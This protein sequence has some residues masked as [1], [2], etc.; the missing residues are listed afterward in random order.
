MNILLT[1]ASGFLGSRFYRELS[2]EN[3]VTTLSRTS[4]GDWPG[5]PRHIQCDLARQVPVLP[6]EP[7][8]IVVHSAGKAHS[9]PRTASERNDYEHVNVQGTIRLLTAL[10]QLPTLPKSLVYISSVLVYG[11]LQ[12]YCLAENTPPRA[13]DVYGLSKVKAE[14]AVR[15]WSERTGVRVAILRLPLVV[16]EQP[17]GNLL[18]MLNAIRRGYYLRIGDGIAR[19]SMVRADDVAG[20][21]TRAADVGGTFNLT[22]GQHPSVCEIENA[23]ARQVGRSRPIPRIS[24]PMA[25]AIAFIGDGLNAIAGRYF[26]LDSVALGKLTNS[27]TFSD[28]LARQHLNWTPRPVLDL[29]P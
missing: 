5:P 26:P 15:Q 12:G 20:V 29:F 21:L 23:L 27:L 4:I 6:N 18:T 22:D 13:Y 11:R 9:I 7:F 28:E 8:D 25:R 1:G 10:E 17:M 3:E 16:A 14:V 24:L 2:P 19:R